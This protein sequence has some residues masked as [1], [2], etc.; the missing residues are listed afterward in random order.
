MV[1]D[2]EFIFFELELFIVGELATSLVPR[3]FITGLF[4]KVLLL[5]DDRLIAVLLAIAVVRDPEYVFHTEGNRASSVRRH[6]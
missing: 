1:S 3:E 5:A 6:L 2:L 4:A